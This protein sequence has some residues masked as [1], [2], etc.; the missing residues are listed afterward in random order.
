MSTSTPPASTLASARAPGDDDNDD[1][2][3]SV[4]GDSVFG[5]V[6]SDESDPCDIDA[7]SDAQFRFL[8]KIRRV[9]FLVT[10]KNASL[11]SPLKTLLRAIR[12]SISLSWINPVFI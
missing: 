2:T 12:F 6:G 10:Y 3:R 11:I 4:G 8:S 5:S 9:I 7:L 1:D